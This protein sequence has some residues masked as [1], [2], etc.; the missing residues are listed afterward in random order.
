MK[1]SLPLSLVCG[2]C[3]VEAPPTAPFR[4]GA[5]RPGDDI[6]HLLTR[7]IDIAQVRFPRTAGEAPNPFLRYRSLTLAWH[8]ARAHGWSDAQLVDTIAA[9]DE[10]VA[11][12]EGHG[13]TVT[14]LRPLP[15]LRKAIGGPAELLAKDET[16]NVSGSHKARH[17]FGVML[18]LRVAEA[19]DLMPA[20]RPLAI[21][22]CGNAALAAAVVAAAARRPLDV[23]I[24]TWAEAPVVEQLRSLGARIQPCPRR[25][26]TPG[27]PCTH[28]FRGAVAAGAIPFSCQGSDNGLAIEGGMTLGYELVA[29]LATDPPD[30]IFIQVGG[31]ALAS[32]V[33]QAWREAKAWGLVRTLPRFHAVQTSNTAPLARAYRRLLT[34]IASELPA[35]ALEVDHPRDS[36]AAR[37]ARAQLLR[38]TRHRPAVAAALH[39]AATHRSLYMWPWEREPESIAHG[40]LDDETYD[41]MEILRGMLTTGGFPIEVDEELLRESRA[42][43]R[44]H[45]RVVA[46]ATG[47]SGLAGLI[48]LQRAGVLRP[49][50]RAL[51]L[52]TGIDRHHGAGD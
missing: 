40:I 1:T 24:P 26:D 23:F 3:G 35:H 13:F 51:V 46:D 43:V 19:L 9:L 2:G 14:P 38:H 17:L 37:D 4:C 15:V 52:L 32:A 20:N 5:A 47:S 10:Q 18:Y 8:L 11:A 48:Q 25:A 27:D 45:S 12:I 34:R 39:H 22:S 16:G 36:L 44:R 41:W 29:A 7:V 33:I 42:L 21:S 50:E 6:D 31:G 49:E 30:R 28:A